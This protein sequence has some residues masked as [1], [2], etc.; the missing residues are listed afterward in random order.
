MKKIIAI[1][2]LACFQGLVLAEEIKDIRI[3]NQAGELYD[4]S[5]VLAFTSFQVGQEVTERSMIQDTIASDVDRMRESGRFAYV[6]AH[7]EI[8]PDGVVLVYTV[9]AKQRI[10]RIEINGRKTW[11]IASS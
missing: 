9:A 5:S 4:I 1:V 10:R 3:V 7:M 2:F 8:E 11:A 6:Q